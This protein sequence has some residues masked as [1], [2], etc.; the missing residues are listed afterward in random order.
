MRLDLAELA[1]KLCPV[2]IIKPLRIG[3]GRLDD[4]ALNI[5]LEDLFRRDATLLGFDVEQARVNQRVNFLLAR[6]NNLLLQFLNF[7]LNRLVDFLNSNFDAVDDGGPAFGEFDLAATVFV[8]FGGRLILGLRGRYLRINI[9][10]NAG[11]NHEQCENAF[12]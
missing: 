1:L 5:G 7:I 9:C 12:H 2:L 6:F 3:V 4:F 10:A 8:F 11:R